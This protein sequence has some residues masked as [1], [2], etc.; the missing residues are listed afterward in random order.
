MP[1]V[2]AMITVRNDKRGTES[3]GAVSHLRNGSGVVNLAINGTATTTWSLGGKFQQVTGNVRTCP[4]QHMSIYS[5][6]WH[7]KRM[8]GS[9]VKFNIN[10]RREIL[11]QQPCLYHFMLPGSVQEFNDDK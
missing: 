5:E 2:P 8:T 4:Q 6:T 11:V 9:S 1:D 3:S 10:E 7:A